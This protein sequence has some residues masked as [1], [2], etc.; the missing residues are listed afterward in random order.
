MLGVTGLGLGKDLLE[1]TYGGYL[2]YGS[3][4][5]ESATGN[6]EMMLKIP[7]ILNRCSRQYVE[8]SIIGFGFE[9]G[10]LRTAYG[11]WVMF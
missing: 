10:I 3:N 9:S 5:G 6:C 8:N 1:D 11:S 2:G 4:E 7:V